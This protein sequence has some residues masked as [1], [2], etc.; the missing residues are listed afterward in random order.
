[1]FGGADP[2]ISGMLPR[3]IEIRRNHFHKP[4]VWKDRW[5]IKNLL[6][7]KIGQRVLVEGNVFENNWRGGQAGFAILFKSTNQ[8]GRATWSQ[9]SDVTFRNNLVKNVAHGVQIAA[10]PEKYSAVKAARFSFSNNVFD[11]VGSG[12]YPGGRLFQVDGI[13]GLTIANNSAVSTHSAILLYGGRTSA[14]VMKNNV[15]AKTSYPVFGDAKG[16]GT[17]ALNYYAPGWIFSGNVVAGG[18]ASRYPAGNSYPSTT[19][20]IGFVSVS[21]G[22]LS[23][24]SSSPYSGSGANYATVTTQTSGVVREYT[25]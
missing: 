22:N 12:T 6:E 8:N 10:K 19:A 23:L 25:R 11:R 15:F 1:M 24:S 13:A 17:P 3:D 18:S 14:L 2:T 4:A 21:T 9:T 20:S 7:L 16:V 5:L